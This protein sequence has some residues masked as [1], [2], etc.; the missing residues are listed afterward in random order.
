MVA[1]EIVVVKLTGA[2]VGVGDGVGHGGAVIFRVCGPAG[3]QKNPT[4]VRML[5][6]VVPNV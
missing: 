5:T 1:G 4:G 6:C 3:R 2:G